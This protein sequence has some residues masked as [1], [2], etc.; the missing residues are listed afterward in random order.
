M[1]TF[2]SVCLLEVFNTEKLKSGNVLI[3]TETFSSMLELPWDDAMIQNV[4][5]KCP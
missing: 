2:M 3:Q 5:S 4:Y 1:L